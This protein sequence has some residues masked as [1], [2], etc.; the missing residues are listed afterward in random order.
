MRC[1][2]CRHSVLFILD[3]TTLSER[4]KKALTCCLMRSGGS[5][6][7]PRRL[8]NFHP[9]ISGCKG[10][11]PTPPS[12]T[13]T[14]SSR[15]RPPYPQRQRKTVDNYLVWNFLAVSVS[16]TWCV[17]VTELIFDWFWGH[18][19]RLLCWCL[20]WRCSP[21]SKAGIQKIM[22]FFF[23]TFLK[24]I[25]SMSS[26]NALTVEMLKPSMMK[27]CS[28]KSESCDVVWDIIYQTVITKK[29]WISSTPRKI[30]DK[31]S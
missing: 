21:W 17:G 4:C 3:G 30:K 9:H 28:I 6:S 16:A 22:V 14:P 1:D 11:L 13:T 19:R 31:I 10:D 26:E 20:C 24:K 23:P 29:C 8:C 2:L 18:A 27:I 25:A 7:P 5:P 12:A 15:P